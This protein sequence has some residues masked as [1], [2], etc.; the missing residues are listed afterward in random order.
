VNRKGVKVKEMTLSE[1]A[2]ALRVGAAI[3]IAGSDD[4][5]MD[6]AFAAMMESL[7]GAGNSTPAPA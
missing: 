7:K 1:L 5:L 3:V 2:L 6:G 4:P